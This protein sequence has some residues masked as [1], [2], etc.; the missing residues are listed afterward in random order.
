ML[1]DTWNQHF[2]SWQLFVYQILSPVN[3]DHEQPRDCL[4]LIKGKLSWLDIM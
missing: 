2:L 1:I 4:S 3:L